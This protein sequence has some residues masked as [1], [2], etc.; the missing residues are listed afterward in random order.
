MSVIQY[1]AGKH[2][3]A[4]MS[5]R[6]TRERSQVRALLL[7][8]KTVAGVLGFVVTVFFHINAR[9]TAV[10]I[11]RAYAALHKLTYAPRIIHL[12]MQMI[13]I[14]SSVFHKVKN[15]FPACGEKC[16]KQDA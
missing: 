7:P 14:T 8:G 16:L 15:H 4:G 1:L 13:F 10:G 2:S 9:L 12:S 11:S 3:S 5:V 6:L